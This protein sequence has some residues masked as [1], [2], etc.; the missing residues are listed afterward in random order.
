MNPYTPTGTPTL[1]NTPSYCPESWQPFIGTRYNVESEA[2]F[3]KAPKGPWSFFH[4][5]NFGEV[6]SAGNATGNDESTPRAPFPGNAQGVAPGTY[7]NSFM[8]DAIAGQGAI[9]LPYSYNAAGLLGNVANP[10]FYYDG[11]TACDSTPG[12]PGGICG[13]NSDGPSIPADVNTLNQEVKSISAVWPSSRIVVMGHNQGGLIAFQWW[14]KNRTKLPPKFLAAFSL[15]SPINGVCIP[16]LAGLLGPACLGLPSYPDYLK[17]ISTKSDDPSYLQQDSSS[18][19]QFH[20]IGTYGDPVN[21]PVLGNA[22]GSGGETLEHQLLFDYNTYSSS[23]VESK[24]GNFALANPVD[25]SGCPAPAPPDHISQCPVSLPLSLTPDWEQAAAHY[26]V[27]F[28][29]GNV[30][31]FNHTLGLSYPGAPSAG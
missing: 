21:I 17:E 14:Q 25:E 11:Y 8:L 9:I 12:E 24:C 28:C 22:Y 13:E 5:W 27:K 4:K 6:D 10:T 16:P 15:D 3:S 19:E 31:Y 7:T 29:P 26:V 2:A 18:G 20:F 23:Q 1:D 30:N